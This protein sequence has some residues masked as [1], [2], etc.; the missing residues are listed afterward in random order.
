VQQNRAAE[1]QGPRRPP[2]GL[3]GIEPHE[4]DPQKFCQMKLWGVGEHGLKVEDLAHVAG[5]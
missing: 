3:P 2:A 1:V 5:Q 4:C